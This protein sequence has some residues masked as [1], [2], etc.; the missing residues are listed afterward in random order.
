[1]KGRR[2]D[3]NDEVTRMRR[4]ILLRNLTPLEKDLFVRTVET[5]LNREDSHLVI[6]DE[7]IGSRAKNVETETLSH[8]KA[9][10]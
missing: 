3:F 5:L 6:D 8:R 9:G 2:K 4:G 1:M 10:K 7:L